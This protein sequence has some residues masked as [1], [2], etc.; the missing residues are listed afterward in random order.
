M[1]VILAVENHDSLTQTIEVLPDRSSVAD[2]RKA[3]QETAAGD[4][5]DEAQ[6]RE[7]LSNRRA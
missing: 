5:S 3:E 4:V 1:A 7:A 2:F 6:V